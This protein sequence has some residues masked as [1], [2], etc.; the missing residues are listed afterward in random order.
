MKR[1]APR[2][3]SSLSAAVLAEFTGT[4]Q[5]IALSANTFTQTVIARRRR[6]GRQRAGGRAPRRR[7]IAS[8]KRPWLRAPLRSIAIQVR[9]TAH[10]PISIRSE[11]SI[12]PL[13][14]AGTGVCPALDLSRVQVMSAGTEQTDPPLPFGD[15]SVKER[16][17]ES[18]TDQSAQFRRVEVWFVPGGADRPGGNR[19]RKTM[20][21]PTTPGLFVRLLP[22]CARKA[23]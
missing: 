10:W 21:S 15:A 5:N 14:S 13:L 18:A 12:R 3:H 11:C 17:G 7:P 2:R 4:G 22:T 20:A 6:P 16:A 8:D 19:P 9:P 23:H 1:F